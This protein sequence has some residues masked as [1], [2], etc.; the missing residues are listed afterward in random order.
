MITAGQQFPITGFYQVSAE[1]LSNLQPSLDKIGLT[2]GE[3]KR[4]TEFLS[5]QGAIANGNVFIP[6]QDSI[7]GIYAKRQLLQR[8]VYAIASGDT[9]G[10]LSKKFK[11]GSVA[12]IVEANANNPYV[13]GADQIAAGGYLF[14]ANALPVAEVAMAP[15]KIESEMPAR[16]DAVTDAAAIVPRAA[17][18]DGGDNASEIIQSAGYAFL[19]TALAETF[20]IQIKNGMDEAGNRWQAARTRFG[21]LVANFAVE[22]VNGSAKASLDRRGR[23]GGDFTGT[24]SQRG[25]YRGTGS[26]I[27]GFE[28]IIPEVELAQKRGFVI[29]D[30]QA[31]LKSYNWDQ[32]QFG[33]GRDVQERRISM[34]TLES[35]KA[36]PIGEVRSFLQ[37][38]DLSEYHANKMAFG[39]TSPRLAKAVGHGSIGTSMILSG[40]CHYM[41]WTDPHSVTDDIALNT[42]SVLLSEATIGVLSKQGLKPFVQGIMGQFGPSWAA[43]YAGSQATNALING[44]EDASGVNLPLLA[45]FPLQIVGTHYTSKALIALALRAGAGNPALGI[46]ARVNPYVGAAMLLVTVGTFVLNT[47][48]KADL[49]R[50]IADENDRVKGLQVLA[51]AEWKKRDAAAQLNSSFPPATFAKGGLGGFGGSSPQTSR[52]RYAD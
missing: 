11:I 27:S 46:L 2:R 38:M 12:S 37:R 39:V 47:K 25:P 13:T 22:K 34:S 19:K 5:S 14:G 20:S 6:A 44:L 50:S 17:P 52:V 4:F 30:P 48:E 16:N 29:T 51:K 21:T 18:Q 28:I 23:I 9:L 31:T 35:L 45:R 33:D 24:S 1:D 36:K 7:P 32:A 15:Q 26:S 41:G 8:P 10:K 3:I 43:T 40:V 49:A 42:M